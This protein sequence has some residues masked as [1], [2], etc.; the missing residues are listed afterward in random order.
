[1]L[2]VVYSNRT[3]TIT[4]CGLE[5]R[6][7]GLQPQGLRIGLRFGPCAFRLGLKLTGLDY[8]TARYQD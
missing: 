8:I 4:D 5:R 6:G 2:N 3:Q 7:L 1:M